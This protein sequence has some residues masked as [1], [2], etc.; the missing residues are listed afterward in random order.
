LP[1]LPD[2]EVFR[3]YL[4]STS[5]HKVIK[6]VEIRDAGVL[7]NVS[8]RRLK[9]QLKGHSLES[10]RRRGKHLLAGLDNGRWLTIHFGMTGYLD[11]FKSAS[12]KRRYDRV[13][14]G[15]ANGYHLAFVCLRKLGR[16]GLVKDPERFF[17]AHSLGPDALELDLDTFEEMMG[18]RR[19]AVKPAL[20]DQSFIAG[21]G[22]MYA[23]EILY[24]AGI[25]P[26]AGVSGLDEKAVRTIFE[27]MKRVLDVAIERKAD[28]E[29]LPRTWLLAHRAEGASCPRC[30][31][32]V[33]RIRMSNRSA[34]LCPQCQSK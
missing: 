15:F 3:E 2:V 4:S 25:D 10:T 17:A 12:G 22:N 16:I 21:I 33:K 24:Q 7:R 14:I 1:E 20:M 34:Y 32:T 18:N 9:K 26:R 8:G 5:L 27:K 29:R 19:G 6:D 28:P 23:D 11:Y 13:V 31:G 30:G